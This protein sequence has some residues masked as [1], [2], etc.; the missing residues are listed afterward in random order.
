MKQLFLGFFL[1]LAMAISIPSFAISSDA[2][3]QAG[4]S[5]LSP[6]QQAKV[7]SDIAQAADD[8]T[9]VSKIDTVDK[10]SKWVQVGTELG[11]G[12]AGAAKELGVAANEFITTPVGQMV[13]L[14]IIWHFMGGTVVHVIGGILVWVVGYAFTYF[15]VRRHQTLDI[16][17]DK[18][19]KVTNK[20]RE[21]L[22]G[23]ATALFWFAYAVITVAGLV[24]IFTY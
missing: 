3:N 14:L 11:K 7:I 17:Y 6:T 13:A 12:L 4:F 18:E 1:V 24:T 9:T 22:D 15:I 20:H 8:T 10:V 21:G 23:D 5:K 2:V 16:S 19:G